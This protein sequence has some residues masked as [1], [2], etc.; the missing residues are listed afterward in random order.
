V[1]ALT[2]EPGKPGTTRLAEIPGPDDIKVVVQ[3][4]EP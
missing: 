3:F 1:Q 2:L 4:A